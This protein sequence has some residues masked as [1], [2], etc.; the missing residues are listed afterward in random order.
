MR[1]L[2]ELLSELRRDQVRV[3]REGDLLRFQ[4]GAKPLSTTHREQLTQRKAEILSFLGASNYASAPELEVRPRPSDVPLSYAQERLWLLNRLQPGSAAYNMSTALRLEGELDLP[5]V[6][7]VLSELARRHESLRTRFGLADGQ[8]T[9]VIDPPAPLPLGVVDLSALA[10]DDQAAETQRRVQAEA[11]TPFDLE[12]G[13]L[14]RASLLRLGAEEHVLLVTMHHIVSDGWSLGVLTRELAALYEAFRRGRPSPLPEPELQYADYALWQRGWLQGEAL[15]AQLAYWREK[16]SDAPAALELP[17]DRPRPPAASFRGASLP[18]SVPQEVSAALSE[19]ARRE[20]A[21]LFM[22][23][24]AAFQT[25]LS[26]WS[27]QDDVVVGSPIAGRTHSRTENLIGFFVNTLALRT[28]LSGDP[29]FAELVR[30]VKETALGAYAHQDLPFEKLVAELAPVRD[31]SRQPVFQAMFTLQNTPQTRVELEGLTLSG[32]SA[33]QVAAKF[34]LTLSVTERDQELFANLDYAVDLFDPDTVGRIAQALQRVLEQAAASPER[35]LSDLDLLGEDERRR[36]LVDW[37]NTD[38]PYPET[39]C[40]HELVGEQAGRT[41]EATAVI[42]GE[43]TLSYAELDGRANQLAHHLRDLGVGPEVVVGL[44]LERSPEMIVGLL[45]I[46]KAGGA[47]LPLDP[48]YPQERLAFMLADAAAPVIVTQ[49]SLLPQFPEHAALVVQIDADAPGINAHPTTAP[50]VRTDP[51]NLAYVIYTSG[52]TG[53]PKGVSLHHGILALWAWT[54]REIGREALQRVVAGTSVCFDLSVF[55]LFFALCSGGTALIAAN[56]LDMPAEHQ[57]TLINTVPSA[58]AELLRQG[59]IPPSVKV[60][61]VAGEPL[62]NQLV[63]ALYRETGVERVY[64]LYGPSETA[65]YSTWALIKPGSASAPIGKPINNERVYVLDGDLKLVPPGVAGE[66]YIAGVGVA[67]GYLNRPGLTAERFVADPFGAPC[68]RMYRTGDRVRWR[69]DGRLE[70]LG[71][72]DD[73]VKIRGYRI[74]LGEIEAALL[75]HETVA[76]TVVIARE[77]GPG[78]GRLVAYLVPADGRTPE[79]EALRTHL[80]RTLP[81]YMVPQAFVTLDALPLSPNG[82]INRKALPA[83]ESRSGDQPFVS[84]ATPVE[85][86]LAELWRDVLKRDRVSALDNFFELGGHSLLG[87]QLMARIS[88]LLQVEQ[89]LRLLFEAPTVRA[90]AAS[91]AFEGGGRPARPPLQAMPRPPTVPL[92][93]AQ[94]RLWLLDQLSTS[95]TAYNMPVALRLQGALNV[96]AVEQTL[97]ELLRRHESL[98]TRFASESDEPVQVIDPPAPLPLAVVDLSALAGDDQAAE[99][100]RRVQ[101]EAETPFD[102]ERG[103]LFRASLLRLGAEEHV[104]L[105]TM[106]HIV[107]DGWSL[108]VLTRELAALY[109]AFRRG[110][111]S[112]LPEPELQYADYALWQRGWLQG[113]ALEAQLAYWRE[114]L[115]DAPAALELPTDRPRPPAASFRGASLPFSVPQ[116][117]SAALS[118]LARREGATLFMVLLAAFQTVLSRWSGQDDV[119]VGSPIAGRT[120]SRTENLIGFFVNTLALRTDLSGDPSFAELV[121]RVKETALGAYAHQDLPFEKLVAELAPVRDLSRQP[122][123]QAMFT[124]QNT[125]QTRVELEG[126]TLSG[127]SADQV[128]AKFDLT[129]SVTERD[130]ELFAN[131][132]YAVDLF[133]PDTVGRIAQALQRVLEQAAASPERR[134]SDLDLLGEDERRRLLVDWNNTDPAPLDDR[135]FH[136]MVG[137]QAQRT[138]GAAA[139]ICGERTLS[140]AELD[141]RANQLAHHLRDLGVGP[142]VVVGLRLE[143]SPEM[144][145]GLLGIL[146]AGG[147]YLPLDPDHPSERLAFMLADAA[148][149]VIVTQESLDAGLDGIEIATVLVD[150]DVG[151]ISDQPST[152]PD[153][154]VGAESLAYVIYTSGSTGRPKGVMVRHQ[155]MTN[156]VTGLRTRVDRLSGQRRLKVTLNAPIVFDG[157]VKQLGQLAHGHTLVIVPNEVRLQPEEFLALIE[158]ENIDLIDGVPSHLAQLAEADLAGVLC[159]RMIWSGGEPLTPAL[160]EKLAPAPSTA[161]YN[162]YGPTECSVV[163]SFGRAAADGGT[164]SIGRPISNVRAY[165]LDRELLP[166]PVGATGELYV[167]GV[168]VARGYLHRPGLTAERFM[169]DPFAADGSRMYRTGDHVRWRENG[170]LDFLGRMDQQVKIR[171][172]R[173]E[174]AEIEAALLRQPGVLGAAVIVGATGRE[175]SISSLTSLL[176]VSAPTMRSSAE[177]LGACCPTTWFRA[178]S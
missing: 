72:L 7:R 170:E 30:R 154:A 125:P 148:A 127:L 15:E 86:M 110:R 41:P 104:L 109:E 158:R 33:D 169:A 111:P 166:V 143:R 161:L 118:E 49:A 48:D 177:D 67:R 11:E 5:A 90:L 112:P 36:L 137:E 42:C 25:V 60:I 117:V 21:T 107:S 97:A 132:D 24:L 130:Q 164:P 73:Q 124:L 55:E 56:P 18:F 175:A 84:P 68:A 32:L 47:Y 116:E 120:H 171:G 19:L 136:A 103:P 54:E 155:G 93:Y 6:E 9:Q 4:T 153:A 82:K 134:L 28:D 176:T 85:E 101:A 156:L 144:I 108:G 62:Q 95:K 141:G 94:E 98:R 135:P 151:A 76:R 89:P 77:D 35:R 45:G 61:N 57:P 142:E 27:G 157:S 1:P 69:S 99:T 2:V 115:S 146:K 131:L 71:R 50:E 83:P 102:L 17:T 113:E 159:G 123:F 29:S 96:A 78:G 70:F 38:A 20:G 126:L 40:L 74:E 37:N 14:F 121:R 114:K 173:I 133:D 43:R 75:D 92:S 88:E 63:Q 165:V 44:C 52:S 66:L 122:V 64:N 59:R 149:P 23:L 139:V 22:V 79:A 106:H 80:R 152:A 26:R 167:A 51:A 46:L 168:G 81:D 145:V 119:V 39:R 58:V 10:G 140:Y 16:L 162:S 53:R 31:L 8:G 65:T 100:Q 129:L 3:W 91:L 172:H 12:R 34:D 87:V 147:A 150:R 174:L 105:V 138:P 163:A 160:R 13:P 128:A 178:S